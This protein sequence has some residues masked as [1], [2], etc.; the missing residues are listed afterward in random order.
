MKTMTKLRLKGD[1]DAADRLVG[2]AM[3]EDVLRK[4]LK[5]R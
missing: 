1:Y 2:I 5:E 3:S 4:S